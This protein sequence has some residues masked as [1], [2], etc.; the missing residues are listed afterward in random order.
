MCIHGMIFAKASKGMV[1]HMLIHRCISGLSTVNNDME[2]RRFQIQASK[3]LLMPT[4]RVQESMVLAKAG[5][6]NTRAKYAFSDCFSNSMARH[7]VLHICCDWNSKIWLDL[8]QWLLVTC[9]WG[10]KMWECKIESAQ[11][12]LALEFRGVSSTLQEED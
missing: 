4:V 11:F 2:D 1:L 5:S 3:K 8:E 10:R 6:K 9:L 12:F 7:F